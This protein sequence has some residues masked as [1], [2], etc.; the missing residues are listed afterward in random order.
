M[1]KAADIFE[2]KMRDRNKAD[3]IKKEL[4][5]KKTADVA[6]VINSDKKVMEKKM[7]KKTMPEKKSMPEKITMPEKKQV[8]PEKKAM[9]QKK[10]SVASAAKMSSK[11]DEI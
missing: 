9:P 6:D 7:K 1:D 2:K 5:R 3:Q 8:I 10:Q 11:D 4:N